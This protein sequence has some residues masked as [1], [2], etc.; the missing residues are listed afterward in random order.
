MSTLPAILDLLPH[1]PPMRLVE[2][3]LD[4]VPG[5]SARGRRVARSDDWYFRG[6]FPGDPLVP[7]IVLVELLAQTG[8][9]AAASAGR[10]GTPA[11]TLRVA[12]FSGF[13]FPAAARPGAVLEAVVRVVGRMGGMIR[14]EGEVT[15]D[16]VRVAIGGV[17]LAEVKG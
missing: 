8:G 3:V 5:E 1:G 2:E 14:V 11:P 4:L 15:A 16:S 17:T 9:I 6:H 13:K 10:V 12:A 7:A